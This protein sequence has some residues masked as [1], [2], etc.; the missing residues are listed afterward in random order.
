MGKLY[1]Y[2][3][4]AIF[5][6]FRY[7]LPFVV[8]VSA[9][10]LLRLGMGAYALF[11][12]VILLCG[13]AILK[14]INKSK[15]V[16]SKEAGIDY[17]KNTK[18][19]FLL[20]ISIDEITKSSS[21]KKFDLQDWS[22]AWINALIQEVG[23]FSSIDIIQFSWD[24]IKS[25]R[26]V[27]ISKSACNR[28]PTN[29]IKI[30]N[31]FVRNGGVLLLEQPSNKFKKLSGIILS[32]I[33]TKPIKVSYIDKDYESYYILKK[34][35]LATNLN[36]VLSLSR[37]VK[38]IA[39][40]DNLPS[41]VYKH[42]GKGEV[43]SLCFDFGLQLVSLQQG[44]P[45]NNYTVTDKTSL[46]DFCE[47]Q[48]LVLDKSLENNEYPFADIL[49]KLVLEII[50]SFQPIPRLWYVKDNY[51]GA[52]I[53]THDEDYFGDG[54]KYMLDE[55]ARFKATSTFF[56]APS[57]KISGSILRLLTKNSEFAIH[58]DR[59]E[60]FLKSIFNNTF[61]DGKDL[62]NQINLL[63]SNYDI[64]ITSNRNHFLKWDNH[65]TNTLRELYNNG[66]NVDSTYG[67]N[68]GKGYLFCTSY[69][70]YPLD[71]NG[72]PI[73]ILEIPFHTQELRA[74][75][76]LD[77]IKCLIKSN[78]TQ[79]HG[80]ISLLFH[81]QKSLPGMKARSAWLGSIKKARDC[82]HWITNFAQFYEFF[83]N[84]Q[85]TIIKSKFDS[86]VL[87]ISADSCGLSLIVPTNS[88]RKTINKI[89][90][91]GNSIKSYKS[92]KILGFKYHLVILPKGKI[93]LKIYYNKN[94]K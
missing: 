94:G 8:I 77:Y 70:F 25:R 53:M 59:M 65:Y 67:P 44:V 69:G 80:I 33:K 40:F 6:G 92:I 27:I 23:S 29:S 2:L 93:S 18:N 52:F 73:P 4:I 28:M 42:Q 64:K 57:K 31:K 62:K 20:I 38:I 66:I 82:G 51:L 90:I 13:T 63:E 5:W 91:N 15:K 75:A 85:N 74:G 89:K 12:A 86:M 1:A 34:M 14:Y 45:Q 3:Y 47:S 88:N 72:K 50:N 32:Q 61:D 10:L 43:I 19:D 78:Q 11:A 17:I 84:R 46:K 16:N 48:D 54:V 26:V 60:Y 55:E 9:V 76:D 36:K 49:E 58:W 37:D 87:S 68:N 79:Y 41:I 35:P 24:L 22:Y 39:R 21:K 7:V 83:Q 81:P 56:V 30:L 71:T